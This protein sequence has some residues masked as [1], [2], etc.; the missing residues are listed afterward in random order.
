MPIICSAASKAI[1]DFIVVDL[2]IPFDAADLSGHRLDR[3][4][5]EDGGARLFQAARPLAVGHRHRLMD[6][7][8]QQQPDEAAGPPPRADRSPPAAGPARLR[9]ERRDRAHFSVSHIPVYIAEAR[10]R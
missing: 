8:G 9:Q 7:A 4:A 2:M 10:R 3:L 5:V 1:A 6:D